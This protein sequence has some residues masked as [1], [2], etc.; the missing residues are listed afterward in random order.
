MIATPSASSMTT[1]V[2]ALHEGEL[3]ELRR[4]WSGVP[5]PAALSG[6]AEAGGRSGARRREVRQ[7]AG[8]SGRPGK[9]R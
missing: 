3:R 8:P 6:A 2:A 9:S 4:A 7:G 5:V 1:D